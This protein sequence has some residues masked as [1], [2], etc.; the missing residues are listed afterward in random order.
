MKS[1]SSRN[2][3]IYM[4]QNERCGV[5][6][7]IRLVHWMIQDQEFKK[8]DEGNGPVNMIEEFQL[9]YFDSQMTGYFLSDELRRC[10]IDQLGFSWWI[11]VFRIWGTEILKW[12]H[13]EICSRSCIDATMDL[14]CEKINIYAIPNFDFSSSFLLALRLFELTRRIWARSIIS[15]AKMEQNNFLINLTHAHFLA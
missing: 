11:W 6:F 8:N 14:I 13:F 4:I 9:T 12:W 1:R 7:T 3:E 10:G 2:T 15:I 5:F